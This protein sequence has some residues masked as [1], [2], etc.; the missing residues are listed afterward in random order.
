VSTRAAVVDV[1]FDG[2]RAD[3]T[4]RRPDVLNAMD[5][6]VFDGLSA[7]VDRIAA[8]DARVVVVSGE[9]RSFCSGIDFN[10]FGELT[11]NPV[12][13]VA[14]AQAGFRKLAALP[15]PTVAAV[16]GHA[17][18]AGLQ[19]AL[20]CDLRVASDDVSL[21]LLEHRFG[22][23]P[24]LCGTHRLPLLVG[25]ARAKKM[26]WLMEKLDAAE[27]L[28]IGL[29]ELV[30]PADELRSTVDGLADRIGGAPPLAVQ[31]VKGLIDAAHRRTLDEGMNAEGDAQLRMFA[32]TDATE[33]VAA[34]FEKR[35]PRFT[36]S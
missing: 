34:F 1:T 19:L 10:V 5:W 2:V 16:Q 33:A 13:M 6:S 25:P 29:V 26:I 31:A 11:Q 17:L 22:I 24:D 30:V 14:R 32:S 3:L 18:G 23:V 35:P 15:I 36:G 28:R 20:A 4:L 27:A 21:G 7:A 9:G 12:E 8:S